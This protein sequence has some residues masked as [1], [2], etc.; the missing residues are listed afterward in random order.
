MNICK[1]LSLNEK[2]CRNIELYVDLM[3]KWNSVYRLVG[4]SDRETIIDKHVGDSLAMRCLFNDGVA[5]NSML[6]LGSGA[7]LPGI[8]IK[9]V[10]DDLKVAL[11]DSQRKRIQFCETVR[12]EV[13]LEGL[14]IFHGR[15]EDPAIIEAVGKVDLVVSRAT[16]SIEEYLPVAAKYLSSGVGWIVAMKGARLD[17]ERV[18]ALAV[19]QS[20]QLREHA[21]RHYK[22]PISG[23]HRTFVVYKWLSCTSD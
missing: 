11:V 10:C 17:E 20:L 8:P 13:G 18:S 2:Q 6:D 14:E 21:I 15:G 12:R 9:I 3:E 19:V 22:L 1:L 4:P 23:D 7:G 5:A 16:W